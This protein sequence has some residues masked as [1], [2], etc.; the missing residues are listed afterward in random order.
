MR[1]SDVIVDAL[2]GTGLAKEV[3]G[4]E[5]LVIGEIN[6]AGKP[7]IA[8]DIPSGLDGRSGVPLGD[9]V[10][11]THTYTYGHPKLGQLLYPGAACRGRLT[12]IDISLP[13]ACED[14]LGFDARLVDGAMVRSFFRERPP[15]SHK[16][17]FGDLAVVA[18]SVGKTGAA[19][20]ASMGGGVANA[21]GRRHRAR[22]LFYKV[23]ITRHYA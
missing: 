22:S 8:V 21:S 6:R 18:G 1:E 14:S 17:M 2:F 10:R 16:G 5:R 3:A 20:M 13:G 23:S 9:A 19:A 15:D 12:V 4:V 7:V 11:A